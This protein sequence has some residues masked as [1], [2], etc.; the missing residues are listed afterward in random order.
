[1]Q[2]IIICKF[3]IL[4]SSKFMEGMQKVLNTKKTQTNKQTKKGSTGYNQP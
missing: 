1:M 4:Y 2:D 3:Y